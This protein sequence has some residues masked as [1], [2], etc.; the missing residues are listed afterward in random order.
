MAMLKVDAF[1]VAFDAAY[2][3][4]LSDAEW[5]AVLDSPEWHIMAAENADLL[6]PVIARF[7]EKLA[8]QTQPLP[9]R[10]IPEGPFQVIGKPSPRLHGFGHVTG[11]GQ[12]SEHMTQ[13]AMLFMKTLLSPYPHARVKA[14]DTT[15]AE[16]FPG[17][18]AILHRGNLPDLYKD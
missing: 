6:A 4:S 11:F 2:A 17:V 9:V 13:P 10:P 5:A 1:R 7:P 8:A 16:A 12:Y 18:A 14:V 15:K 3:A